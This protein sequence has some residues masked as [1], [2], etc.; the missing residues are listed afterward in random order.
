MP[1]IDTRAA[2]YSNEHDH[3]YQFRNM[4]FTIHRCTLSNSPRCSV[5]N[6]QE[7]RKFGKRSVLT[8]SVSEY[9]ELLKWNG[10]FDPAQFDAAKATRRRKKGLPSW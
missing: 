10:P 7:P 3:N 8:E 6:L 4:R 2:H 1:P 9:R 5:K